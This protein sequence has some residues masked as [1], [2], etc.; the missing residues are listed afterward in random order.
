MSEHARGTFAVTLLPEES[1]LP[2]VY[3]LPDA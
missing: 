3:E 1:G 2:M